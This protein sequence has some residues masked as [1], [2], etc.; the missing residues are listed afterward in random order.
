MDLNVLKFKY[1]NSTIDNFQELFLLNCPHI[2]V[3][4][5]YLE[6][7]LFTLTFSNVKILICSSDLNQKLTIKCDL[8]TFFVR[9]QYFDNLILTNSGSNS[10][11]FLLFK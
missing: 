10:C 1:L 5:Y 6:S 7:R 4:L 11:L 2:D 8:A 9:T 3:K